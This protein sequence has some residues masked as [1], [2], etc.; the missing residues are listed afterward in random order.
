MHK[1]EK[2]DRNIF[3]Q[4][5]YNVGYSQPH[6]LYITLYELLTSDVLINLDIKWPF[7]SQFHTLKCKCHYSEHRTNHC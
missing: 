7:T 4:H 5:R 2:A 1:M 3:Q 6:S